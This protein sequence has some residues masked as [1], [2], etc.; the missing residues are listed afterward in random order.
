[1]LS[2]VQI[3]AGVRCQWGRAAADGAG[4]GD[5]AWDSRCMSACFKAYA[6]IRQHTS[7]YVSI[8]MRTSALK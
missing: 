5:S 2:C 7:A 4:C 1:V 3:C 6:S 8:R